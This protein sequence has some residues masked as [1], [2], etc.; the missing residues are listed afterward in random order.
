MA[1][2]A[3]VLV[4][5][6]GT[7]CSTDGGDARA[8]ADGGGDAPTART[9]SA[10]STPARPDAGTSPV[11]FRFRC[12]DDPADPTAGATV[13]ATYAAVWAAS[14]RSCTAEHV[15]G[16]VPSAQQQAA[17][18]ATE[19]HSTLRGLAAACAVTGDAFVPTIRT[20]SEEL[21]AEGVIR[22]CP[23]HP[24]IDRLRAAVADSRR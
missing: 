4:L 11:I 16:T 17:L 1:L 23:G 24:D 18:D 21:T 8:S 12:L 10:A 2:S 9:P 13:F 19:G 14:E 15:V 22:Y 3:A 20:R 5:L 6:G 7:A